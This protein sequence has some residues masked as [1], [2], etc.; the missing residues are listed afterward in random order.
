MFNPLDLFRKKSKEE[1][2]R[3]PLKLP[4]VPADQLNVA[5]IVALL[6]DDKPIWAW[7]SII[8]KWN[9]MALLHK[10]GNY[11]DGFGVFRV[12]DT[13]LCHY[14]AHFDEN[15]TVHLKLHEVSK[16]TNSNV[17]DIVNDELV[18]AYSVMY[19]DCGYTENTMAFVHDVTEEM[20]LAH[21][22]HNTTWMITD[23]HFYK[24]S[25]YPYGLPNDIEEKEKGC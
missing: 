15:G 2:G 8:D 16:M 12:E 25:D 13:L 24:K 5:G 22:E 6:N 21:L 23:D 3:R 17:M 19:D 18:A 11:L 1:A 14:I 20:A 10:T 4:E 9:P 7:Y